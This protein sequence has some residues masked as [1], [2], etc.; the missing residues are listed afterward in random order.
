[1]ETELR[2][3]LRTAIPASA[4]RDA[5]AQGR[6]GGFINNPG[7]YLVL[8]PPIQT[9]T[10]GT[11]GGAT[12]SNTSPFFTQNPGDDFRAWD[13]TVTFDYMPDQFVTFRT[14]LNHRE[15]NVPYFAGKGGVTSQ[16]GLNSTTQSASWKPDLSKYE[17]RLN[18]AMMVRF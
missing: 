9:S 16:D 2:K 3:R 7:R 5:A 14:E 18:L 11:S 15:A 8:V 4:I 17:D 10:T 6:G 13:A 12:A 1:M